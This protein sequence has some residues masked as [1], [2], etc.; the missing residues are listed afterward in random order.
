MPVR[1]VCRAS[2]AI[3]Q[4]ADEHEH[5][6]AVQALLVCSFI[7]SLDMADSLQVYEPP[8]YMTVNTAIEQLLGIEESRGEG[9]YGPDTLCVGVA[10]L[11]ADSQQIVAGSME[12][13]RHA[14]F[15]PP[16]HSLVIAGD[17]HVIEMEILSAY[18]IHGASSPGPSAVRCEAH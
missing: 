3:H 12:E 7:L 13:L 4:S 2:C 5:I 18:R 14:D 11:G 15:G 9:A 1:S 16:L 8:R 6:S 10:R 17:T